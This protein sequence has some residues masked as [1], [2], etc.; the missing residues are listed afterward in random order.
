[1]WDQLSTN[2]SQFNH[3]PA[4]MH[5]LYLDGHVELLDFSS[6]STRFPATPIYAGINGS[7][8]PAQ[9]SYCYAN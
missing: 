3:V 6:K 9:Y 4:G 8:H 2:I 1:M 7:I 5:V